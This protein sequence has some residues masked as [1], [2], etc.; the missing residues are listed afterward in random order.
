MFWLG[1]SIL[2]GIAAYFDFIKKEVPDFVTGFIWLAYSL[3]LL[4]IPDQ[5]PGIVIFAFAAVLV[6]NTLIFNLTKKAMLAWGDILLLPIWCG[7][8]LPL[9]SKYGFVSIPYFLWSFGVAILWFRFETKKGV[10]LAPVL[11]FSY[12]F[13][14]LLFN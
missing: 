7:I 5:S 11:F 12:L 13:A 10:P 8:V 6:L 14:L 3:S 9:T 4:V 2:F 1:Y